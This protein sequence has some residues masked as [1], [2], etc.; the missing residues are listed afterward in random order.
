VAIADDISC[1][2]NGVFDW[3]GDE[4]TTYSMLEF[5]RDYVAAL[6]DDSQAR[7]DDLIDITT[8]TPSD[9][10]TSEIVE[11]QGT[12][13]VTDELIRHL[14]GG[15]VSWDS[16]NT[17]VSGYKLFGPVRTGTEP[18]I[19]QDDKV[20][21]P[22][23]GT[24]WN[25]DAATNVVMQICIKTRVDGADIDGKVVRT[26]AREFGDTWKEFQTILGQAVNVAALSTANDLNNETAI[27]TVRGWTTVVFTE[28][29]LADVILIDITNDGTDEEYSLSATKGSQTLNESYEVAK[30]R[31]TR[32]PIILAS[33]STGTN[34]IVDNATTVGVGQSFTAHAVAEKLREVRFRIKIGAGAPTG[35]MYV[36]LIDSDAG[37]PPIPQTPFTVLA[38]SETIDV[39]RIL[40]D[41]V[42]SEV[43]FRF[44]DNVTLT[45]SQQYF[46]VLRHPTGDASNYLHADSS[47]GGAGSVA[48]ES[49][50]IENPASTWTGDA[51]GDDLWCEVKGSE[52]MYGRAG[53]LHRGITHEI[54]YDTEA[55]GP[56]TEAEIVYWGTEITYNGLVSGPWVVGD[57]V[58]FA[59]DGTG[60]A[61]NGG[62]ILAD[63]GTV[64]TVALEDISGNLLTLDDI[65]SAS[66]KATTADINGTPE[67]GG[68]NGQDRAGGEAV[69]LTIDDNG[70]T[71]DLY[72][73]LIHGSKPVDG[74][75]IVG[76]T[77]AATCLVNVT[78]TDRALSDVW[79]GQSTGTNIIS[80]Y[81]IGYSTADVGVGDKLKDLADVVNEPPNNVTN[82]ITGL[83]VDEDAVHVGPRTGTALNK[84]LWTTDV[85]LNAA[86]ET[87]VSIAT[88]AIPIDTPNTGFGTD[89]TRLR[90][91]R[92]NGVWWVVPYLSYDGTTPGNFTIYL[93]DT[94]VGGIAMSVDEPSGE[95]RR[96][97]GSFLDDGF[98]EGHRFASTNF[99][100]AGNNSTWTVDR[101][102]D[103]ALTVVTKTGMVTEG[104]GAD[105]RLLCTGMDFTESTHG[106]AATSGN[107]VYPAYIDVLAPTTSVSYTAEYVSDRNTL[108]RIRDGGGT[109]TKTDEFL[110]VFGSSNSSVAA[111]RASDA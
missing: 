3:T 45:A 87:S 11:L 80:A 31:G 52:I 111:I 47:T 65:T 99:T 86:A 20:L 32:A 78:V 39:G 69:L 5:H 70:A 64:L 50:A 18:M 107:D 71:G 36:E 6:Y 9:K 100:N 94:G 60:I 48:G 46:V 101:V 104:A 76:R 62:K 30:L 44:N 79:L 35:D 37:S 108:S 10:K 12:F 90:V 106:G 28:S 67:L 57:Y 29:S 98:E 73:Q 42:Y 26:F 92:D 17:L 1:D 91:Q 88:V 4:T 53:E 96:A 56:F 103:L 27:A 89:T 105:E 66:G 109:P 55:G 75:E 21:P 2:I 19:T 43:I 8:D 97:T 68:A 38:T 81:G 74:L 84:A 13:E 110:T 51:D 40:S 85:T 24:A 93:A 61:K 7:G 54:V 102:T 72:V 59:A 58:S 41:T 25:A 63:T 82:T 77:S 34:N 95:F 23:W 15:S 22:Y 83:V 16:G 14:Y 33:T 49:M